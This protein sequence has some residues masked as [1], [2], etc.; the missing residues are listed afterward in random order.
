VRELAAALNIQYRRLVDGEFNH[1]SFVSLLDAQGRMVKQTG[2]LGT[3]DPEFVAA[4]QGLLQGGS[5]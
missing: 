2:K 5:P 4:L 1:A 3:A